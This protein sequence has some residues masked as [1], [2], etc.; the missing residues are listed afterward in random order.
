ML[1]IEH[2]VKLV[3]NLYFDQ[4]EIIVGRDEED[5]CC[6]R[7]SIDMSE[8]DILPYRQSL[9]LLSYANRW[10]DFSGIPLIRPVEDEMLKISGDV[11]KE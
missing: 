3:S 1:S 11:T 5:D 7:L 6:W 9:E 10:D 2:G 4:E 8:Q